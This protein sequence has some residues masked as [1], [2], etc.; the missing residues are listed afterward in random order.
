M[1]P[2]Y[3]L[4]QSTTCA[5]AAVGA[6]LGSTSASRSRTGFAGGVAERQLGELSLAGEG[7]HEG[8][9]VLLVRLGD[10]LGDG[11]GADAAAADGVLGD[12]EE[13]AG[14]QSAAA[15]A[16]HLGDV[17]EY[18]GLDGQAEGEGGLVDEFGVGGRG[19]GRGAWCRR[20]P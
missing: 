4:P 19:G 10:G 18:F 8:L 20:G 6:S 9:Q 3:L 13:D 7:E 12:G 11:W 14:E 16:G 17:V 5:Q 15:E 1:A 2:T